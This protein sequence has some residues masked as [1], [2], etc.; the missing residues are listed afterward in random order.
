MRQ[1]RG[2]PEIA[3]SG[4]IRIHEIGEA[5]QVGSS[6]DGVD[7]RAGEGPVEEGHCAGRQLNRLGGAV[8]LGNAVL[9]D[10]V[11]LK[12]RGRGEGPRRGLKVDQVATIGD[13]VVPL[14][15]GFEQVGY[16]AGT[17]DVAVIVQVRRTEL[18]VRVRPRSRVGRR[19]RTGNGQRIRERI[20]NPRT[21]RE[22]L[23]AAAGSSR[24]GHAHGG[25]HGHPTG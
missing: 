21:N 1:E 8:E 19:Q 10:P 4:I 22:R 24:P 12:H 13:R 3:V 15:S 11:P 16:L 23:P 2:H 20:Q 6:I 14:P 17:T 25:Q 9:H 5:Y 7:H 18:A